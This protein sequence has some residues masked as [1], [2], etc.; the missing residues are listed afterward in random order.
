MF[1]RWA[2]DS[3]IANADTGYGVGP[4][5]DD[6]RRKDADKIAEFTRMMNEAMV[7]VLEILQMH[8]LYGQIY[9]P[10]LDENGAVIPA[11]NLPL[12]MGRMKLNHVVP[13]LAAAGGSGGFHQAASALLGINGGP[14]GH[15]IAWNVADT[16]VVATDANPIYD[17]SIIADLMDDR[18]NLSSDQL[19]MITSK[20][21]I[22][23]MHRN[24]NIMDYILG[25]TRDRTFLNVNEV[26]D[27]FATQFGFTIEYYQSKWEY[28]DQDAL[29]DNKPP[30]NQVPFLPYG[31]VLIVPNPEIQDL[32]VTAT[33]P[34]PGPAHNWRD[35]K[36]F[37][38]ERD[39][40]PP[41]KTDMG[42]GAFYWPLI[43]DTDV[44]FRLDAW[45]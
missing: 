25:T 30:I 3:N 17:M 5:A 2:G 20:R 43:F 15:N 38:I 24:V 36:Y 27:F 42:I 33:C 1:L 9:W 19:T 41:W 34:A 4:A 28:V 13:F 10:P 11:A 29:A 45:Q 37:W 23:Y 26:R 6:Y 44:R 21:V 16:N 8:S 14:T 31:T 35:G 12:S 32:G 22:H 7:N 18:M 39:E 40:K